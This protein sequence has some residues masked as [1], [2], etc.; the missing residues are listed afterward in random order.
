MTTGTLQ[1]FANTEQDFVS[2]LK[3]ILQDFQANV[4]K[5][6]SLFSE[7]SKEDVDA[8]FGMYPALLDFHQE[9]LL[10]RLTETQSIP[11]TFDAKTISE[12][13]HAY[14]GYIGAYA[15][16]QIKLA[17]LRAETPAFDA[18]ISSAEKE[19]GKDLSEL[20]GLPITNTKNYVAFLNSYI[21]K[22]KRKSIVKNARGEDDTD[23]ETKA[24]VRSIEALGEL[25]DRLEKAQNAFVVQ[26]A[27]RSIKG[28][29]QED[30]DEVPPDRY[31]VL[32]VPVAILPGSTSGVANG[33]ANGLANVLG[34][35]GVS[36]GGSTSICSGG[37]VPGRC[38]LFNDVLVVAK[39]C[40]AKKGEHS[41]HLAFVARYRLQELA[42]SGPPQGEQRWE[43]EVAKDPQVQPQP[44]SQPQSQSQSQSQSQ[45]QSQPQGQLTSSSL[46]LHLAFGT[47]SEVNDFRETCMTLRKEIDAN[48]STIIQNKHHNNCITCIRFT[49]TLLHVCTFIY[50]FL[51]TQRSE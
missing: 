47:S 33:L 19:T 23:D 30:K 41:S 51:F 22:N 40:A 34:G 9:Q 42:M 10:Q 48:K 49:L 2:S 25:C 29:P 7:V 24:I 32:D 35:I 12:M 16:A 37:G 44:Q 13:F 11:E 27:I 21:H 6:G 3:T 5:D 15:T 36:G 50:L 45:P 38:I 43:V 14:R 18:L 20:M 39:K 26:R 1:L 28:Y 17:D 46:V 31:L 4:L 8:V